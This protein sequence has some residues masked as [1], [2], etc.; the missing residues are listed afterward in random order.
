MAPTAHNDAEGMTGSISDV[1][2]ANGDF[3]I[4]YTLSDLLGTGMKLD[5][6]YVPVHGSGDATGDEGYSGNAKGNEDA[7]DITLSG[8]VPG[9]E[10]LSIGA[11]YAER[12]YDHKVAGTPNQ[13]RYDG[14]MYA[15][16]QGVKIKLNFKDFPMPC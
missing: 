8:S 3:G 1:S 10:G 14:T 5:Y 2:G 16:I 6:N 15:L 13:K 4:R 7:H 9:V 11:G 12:S